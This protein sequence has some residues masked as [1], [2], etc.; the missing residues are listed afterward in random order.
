M[1]R[2]TQNSTTL[3]RVWLILGWTL[4]LLI[5]V[6]SLTPRGITV[7]VA[8]GDKIGHL[9]AYAVLMLW[10]AQLYLAKRSRFALAAASL[11]L[12]IGL[13]FAQLLTETRSFS[14]AD[15][16]ADGLG[17]LIGWSIAPPRSKNLMLTVESA[18][19]KHMR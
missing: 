18:W 5:I 14:V 12:G 16:F 11:G 19:A 8:E 4:V 10:F 17:I 1:Q 13:E 9:L 7:P 2:D 3:R 15:M 6:L